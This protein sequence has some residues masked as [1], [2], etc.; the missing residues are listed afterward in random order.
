MLKGSFAPEAEMRLGVDQG[1]FLPHL[2]H[3]L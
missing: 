2:S 3:W 1:R